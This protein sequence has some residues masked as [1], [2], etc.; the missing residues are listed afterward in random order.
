MYWIGAD[1]VGVRFRDALVA[2]ARSG[3]AVFVTYDGIGS[4]GLFRSFWTPL[5]DAGG[6]VHEHGPVAPWRRRFRFDQLL[7]RDHRKILVV[8]GGVRSV[9][10]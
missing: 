3:V 1:G 5:L 8:D 9:A 10:G 6:R 2:R 4:L 7:F